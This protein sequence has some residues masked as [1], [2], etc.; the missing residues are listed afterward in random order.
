[1]PVETFVLLFLLEKLIAYIIKKTHSYK[2]N[3]ILT[4]KILTGSNKKNVYQP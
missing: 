4:I 3:K 1:M 2:T